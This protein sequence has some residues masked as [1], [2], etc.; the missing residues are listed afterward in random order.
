MDDE[1]CN[2]HTFRRDVDIRGGPNNFGP[3]AYRW[4]TDERSI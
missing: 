3:L 2:N 4:S 1:T